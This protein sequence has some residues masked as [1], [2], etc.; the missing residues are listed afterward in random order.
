MAIEDYYI[1]LERVPVSRS[2]DAFGDSAPALGEPVPFV[3]YI[4]KPSS[5]AVERMGQRGVYATGRIYAP[6]DSGVAVWDVIRDG[7]KAWQVVTEPRD[8]ARRGHHVEA[9]LTEWRGL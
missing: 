9:D 5:A 4:G 6:C 7:G 2:V 8:V 1:T 3:G